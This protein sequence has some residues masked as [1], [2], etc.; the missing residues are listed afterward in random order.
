[1]HTHQLSSGNE[2]FGKKSG[3]GR[4]VSD[5]RLVPLVVDLTTV[6]GS[7]QGELVD[8]SLTGAR[9]RGV[10][11]AT[12]GRDLF[13]RLEGAEVFG[14]VAWCAGELCGVSFETSIDAA[15]LER[16]QQE[17]RRAAEMRLTPLQKRAWDLCAPT[18]PDERTAPWSLKP[19]TS[20][21]S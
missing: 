19:R 12:Q 1:M 8:I 7:Y 16:L 14:A 11:G 5:R 18:R 3:G 15:T 21:T 2:V 6:S 9:I 10:R 17:S 4:R 13:M 20:W